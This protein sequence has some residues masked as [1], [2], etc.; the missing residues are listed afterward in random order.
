LYFTYGSEKKDW[1]EAATA[2]FNESATKLADGRVIRVKARAFGSGEI[3]EGLLNEAE[4][5][6]SHLVSPAASAFLI[7]GNADSNEAGGGPLAGP[8][9]A[10]VGS[11]VVVAMW[12]EQAEALGWPEKPISWA[13]LCRYVRDPAAW[14]AATR[15]AG[16]GRFTI[17]H[18]H[19][20]R[21]S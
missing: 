8:T 11:P 3:I 21:S 19:P 10:L 15:G 7:I 6:K 17:A 5:H 16:K 4:E 20:D 18:T 12:R 1:I 2:R 9:V 13:D 14:A